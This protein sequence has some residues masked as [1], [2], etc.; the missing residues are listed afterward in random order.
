MQGN[1]ESPNTE[2][3][4]AATCWNDVVYVQIYLEEQLLL[5]MSTREL[6]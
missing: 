6:K 2:L 1:R 3:T 4:S 5:Q